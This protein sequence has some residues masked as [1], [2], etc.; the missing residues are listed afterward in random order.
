MDIMNYDGT[1]YCDKCLDIDLFTNDYNKGY[2][3]EDDKVIIYNGESIVEE[4][5]FEGE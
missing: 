5:L 1:K 4:I 2:K 3:I